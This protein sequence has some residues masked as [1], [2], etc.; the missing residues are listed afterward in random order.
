MDLSLTDT[1]LIANLVRDYEE[2]TLECALRES[3]F[4][5][6]TT[7]RLSTIDEAT[8]GA[9][10]GASSMD[11]LLSSQGGAASNILAQAYEGDSGQSSL[12]TEM[13][14]LRAENFELLER[15]SELESALE[16]DTPSSRA[17][18]PRKDA[19][20]D[21]PT[22]LP[23]QPFSLTKNS[24]SPRSAQSSSTH[25]SRSESRLQA[26]ALTSSSSSS[27]LLAP[28]PPPSLPAL[29]ER[30]GVA[31]DRRKIAQLLQEKNILELKKQALL[32][33]QAYEVSRRKLDLARDLWESRVRE[34]SQ[35]SQE[36]Q[37]EVE[38]GR[39]QT[40]ELR[41]QVSRRKLDLARDLWESRVREW[42][43]ASQEWQE[44]VEKGRDQT[45][46]L[47]LQLEARTIEL[48]GTKAQLRMLTRSIENSG[49]SHT[50]TMGKVNPLPK[51][52]SSPVQFKV[53]GGPESLVSIPRDSM[54]TPVAA[55]SAVKIM[56]LAPPPSSQL[57]GLAE[58]SSTDAVKLMDLA[59]PPSSQLRGLAEGS[60]TESSSSKYKE[61]IEAPL[62]GGK[63]AFSGV[64]ISVPSGKSGSIPN[65]MLVSPSVS[66]S[67][68]VRRK[69]SKNS[70]EISFR[71]DA[72]REDDDLIGRSPKDS[73]TAGGSAKSSKAASFLRNFLKLS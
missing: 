53:G 47:R 62:E 3:S 72:L 34:W 61:S 25:R 46:E 65:N 16:E 6:T 42:S 60:S 67:L 50:P 31:P 33:M 14:R 24:L 8:S 22:D 69:N 63:P 57:R 7:G 4:A 71:P 10:R 36:W 11:R 35:A 21:T 43:Q 17:E 58:G 55:S 44:E 52:E 18:T 37:E 48:E 1:R 64:L 26:H 54:P 5:A 23:Q 66:P 39:D 27:T 59:P 28:P 30:V 32:Y 56:D 29:P 19:G 49:R 70:A 45:Q 9:A 40:Q 38:K 15:I 73:P 68:D 20:T 51:T 41:L 2:R 12:L 13:E